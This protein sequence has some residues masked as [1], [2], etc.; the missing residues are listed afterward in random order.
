MT[1]Y[2][3]RIAKEWNKNCLNKDEQTTDNFAKP[4][5]KIKWS[6]RMLKHDYYMYFYN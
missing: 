2:N 1:Y 6:G 4:E 3:H 5:S